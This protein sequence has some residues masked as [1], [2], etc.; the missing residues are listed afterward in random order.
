MKKVWMLLHGAMMIAASSCERRATEQPLSPAG[1]IEGALDR[2]GDDA[3]RAFVAEDPCA[4][5]ILQDGIEK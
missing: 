3:A 1:G 2:G 4:A 5:W